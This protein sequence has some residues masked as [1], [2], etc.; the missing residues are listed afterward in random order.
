MLLAATVAA[1][2]AG[3]SSPVAT[4]TPTRSQTPSPSPSAVPLPAMWTVHTDQ[5]ESFSIATPDAWD[6]VIRDSSSFA[7]DLDAVGKHSP[8]LQ[9]YFKK[10]I[11]A[12]SELRLIAADPRSLTGGFAAN[13]NVMRSDLGA[14]ARAPTLAELGAAKL[15]RL[16]NE[17][18]VQLPVQHTDDTLAGRAAVRFDYALKAA[19]QTVTVRSYVIVFDR[20]GRRTMLELTMGAPGDQAT[21]IFDT[22]ARSFKL[23]GV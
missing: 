4:P 13:V 3:C 5:G 23:A 20:G 8:E 15:T 10:S 12:N 9:T 1:G 11:D 16:R 6:Y 7:S 18:A 14:L 21:G 17:G 2:V 22:A 19:D